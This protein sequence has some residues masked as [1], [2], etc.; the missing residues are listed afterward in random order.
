MADDLTI[1][2]TVV[3]G[4]DTLA[5]VE[6]FLGISERAGDVDP[7]TGQPTYT[8]DTDTISARVQ[9]LM[10]QAVGDCVAASM[11]K[12]IAERQLG[13]LPAA[14]AEAEQAKADAVAASAVAVSVA[15]STLKQ[16]S[17]D[18]TASMAEV[19]QPVMAPPIGRAG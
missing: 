19:A 1:S 14:L 16:A 18:A 11:A 17:L 3:V 9:S 13:L 12:A 10:I 5:A 6:A 15:S 4:G 8:M 2:A 7:A